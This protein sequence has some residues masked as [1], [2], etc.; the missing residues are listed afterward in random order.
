MSASQVYPEAK[1][2]TQTDGLTITDSSPFTAVI[3]EHVPSLSSYEELYKHFHRN[4]E[5]STLEVETSKRIVSELRT[6]NEK[7]GSP[8]EIKT[9]IAKTGLIGIHR[10]GEGPT[11]LLRAD[12]DAM[13]VRERTGLEYASTKSMMDT[14]WD[15]IEKPVMH[16]CGHDFHIT[17]MLAAIE[18]LLSAQDKWSG[19]LIYLFQPAEERGRGARMM[20][21]D[22][23]YDKN[24]HAC[25]IPDLCLGQHVF[26][27]KSGTV[28]TKSG[29][30]MAAADSYKI[31]IHGIGGHGSQPHNCID[32]VVIAS[33][34]VIKLQTLVSREIPPGE[35]AVVT[36]G[37]VKAG[38]TVNVIS[39][40][41][42]MLVN[43]RSVTPQWRDVLLNGLKRIIDAECTSSRCPKPAEYEK[44]NE[45][46]FTIND[47]DLTQK[48]S[49]SF[50]EHFGEDR[51]EQMM[52]VSGSEDFPLLATEVGKP[53]LFWFF[54][55]T[56]PDE[57]DRRRK[58]GTLHELPSNH[59]PYFAPVI[60][61]T[62]QT[63]VEAMVVA[64]LTFV[65]KK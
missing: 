1:I 22:G 65:G 4:P 37:S 61:P 56:D 3:K 59:S 64:A 45:F 28:L 26:P 29:S 33:Y 7:H 47:E 15:N 53:Y 32:P 31:T 12:I 9:G 23:V 13:P 52:T 41:A 62:L 51:H 44:L 17:S 58:E 6:L 40:T 2:T 30:T 38:D 54:G 43:I 24:R 10:N 39:D 14:D 8:I 42:V 46:P 36:V 19:T 63:G 48:V 18:T 60:Q 20:L 16:A 21:D 11:I 5:I 50:I 57:F 49:K 34:I 35:M 55:G 27:F 25:P